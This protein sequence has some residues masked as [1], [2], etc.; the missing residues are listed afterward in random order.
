MSDLIYTQ[1]WTDVQ[2]AQGWGAWGSQVKSLVHGPM[3]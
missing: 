3:H 2:P 1:A